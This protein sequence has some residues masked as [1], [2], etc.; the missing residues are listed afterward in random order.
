[1]KTQ[2]IAAVIVL[3]AAGSLSAG[4]PKTTTQVSSEF[5]RMKNLVGTWKGSADMGQGPMDFTVEYR[6]TSGGSAIEERIFAGTPK[7]MVT[8]YYDRQGKLGLTHYCMLGNR[9]AMRLKSTDAKMIKFDFD[10]KCGVDAKSETHMHS[11]TI[12]FNDVDT[13]T[14]EWELFEAGKA[15]ESHPFTLKRVKAQHRE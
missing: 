14:Q 3:A 13:I 5:D 15:K 4:E 8:M 1:M 2:C 10:P 11:L 12:T 6:L 7:E 9:P